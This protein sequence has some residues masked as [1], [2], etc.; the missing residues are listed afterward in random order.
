MKL[1]A[2]VG[3]IEY[4]FTGINK[5]DWPTHKLS[6]RYGQV[7]YLKVSDDFQIYQTIVI[8]RYLAQEGGLY[9]TD[10]KQATLTE[11]IVAS[12]DEVLSGF[13]KVFYI[14]PEDKRPEELKSF[15]E[16][17]LNRIFTALDKLLEKNATN[18]FIDGQLTWADLFLLDITMT[19]TSVGVDFS[20][21]THIVKLRETLL[22]NEK[23]KSFLASDRS[24][25]KKQ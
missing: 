16:G 21:A 22:E 12:L 7:P 13:V 10:R 14:T 15:T 6:T 3:S 2:E 20:F 25:R 23:V 11:E 17:T 8:A 19:L 9:P 4:K 24:L 18:N 1:V 5:Q